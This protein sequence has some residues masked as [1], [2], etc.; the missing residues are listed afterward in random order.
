[1]PSQKLR[2]TNHLFGMDIADQPQLNVLVYVLFHD[3]T[4]RN[5][6]WLKSCTAII[7]TW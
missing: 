5:I 7:G 2:Q 3:F 6:C 1:M 4:P